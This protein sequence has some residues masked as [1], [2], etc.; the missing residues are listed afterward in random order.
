MKLYLRLYIFF[1]FFLLQKCLSKKNCFILEVNRLELCI[2]QYR[3][4]LIVSIFR[5]SNFI[6][7]CPMPNSH[8]RGIGCMIFGIFY[9]LRTSEVVESIFCQSNVGKVKTNKAFAVVVNL[10]MFSILQETDI[11]ID[12][13]IF[14]N[15][16]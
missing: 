10:P 5:Q 8:T 4:T 16:Q 7:V 1:L 12:N 6:F 15:M 13:S 9:N 14:K 11:P 3:K 2:E